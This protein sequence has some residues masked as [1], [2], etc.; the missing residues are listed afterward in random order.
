M[1][2]CDL[3]GFVASAG[4]RAPVRRL[5][6][7][8]ATHLFPS[9]GRELS[10]PWLAEQVDALASRADVCVLAALRDCARE[11]AVR[12]SG[13][14]VA[15]RPTRVVPGSGRV[16]LLAAAVRYRTIAME[17]FRDMAPRPDLL[18]AHFGF[19]D[20]VVVS[21]VAAK[22]GIPWVATLHGDDAFFLLKRRDL[23]GASI[24]DAL[25]SASAVI[26]VSPA[27]SEVVRGVLGEHA[28]VVTIENG[29]DD[30]LFY[31]G[32]PPRTGGMLF[33]GT[34][35]RVKNVDTLIRAYADLADPPLLT[36][37]GDGPL[38]NELQKLTAQL[39]VDGRVSFLG[40][41]SREEV[42]R[43]MQDAQVLVIPSASEGYGMVAAEA[44]ACGTPVIASKVGGLVRIVASPG[45]GV[46]VEPGSVD[47]LR[48]AIERVL[49]RQWEP[50]AVAR[51]SGARPWSERACDLVELY[52]RVVQTGS[53]SA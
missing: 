47:A 50:A 41:Q 26:C 29:Y 15:Y 34:L 11:D 46:L 7:A 16:A 4:S 1:I 14:R 27:M 25:A 31:P 12:A 13:V 51:S 48:D 38:R 40:V 2:A 5:R 53:G 21:K 49:A 52:E 10:G 43:L 36:I 22:L 42:A 18:H 39:E 24:R 17:H 30:A 3:S 28:R 20:A 44:L 23:L 19:P 9:E 8:I 33:A 6:I 32:P 35:T 45:A 37:A